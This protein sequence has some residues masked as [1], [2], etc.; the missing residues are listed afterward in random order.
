MTIRNITILL[1]TFRE[2]MDAA[3]VNY[4]KMNSTWNSDGKFKG[5]SSED[6]DEERVSKTSILDV[7]YVCNQTLPRTNV[8]ILNDRMSDHFPLLLEVM[9]SK[10]ATAARTIYRRNIKSLTVEKWEAALTACGHDWDIVYTK[11]WEV[12]ELSE[13]IEIGLNKAQDIAAPMRKVT[14]KPGKKLYLQPD[15]L[16]LMNLRDKTTRNSKLRKH[17]QNRVLCLVKR[18]HM[19]TAMRDIAEGIPATIWDITN[20][21]LGKGEKKLPTLLATDKETAE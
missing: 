16:H 9:P 5:K 19:I 4:L 11:D 10:A 18:D 12:D 15:T 8:H 2:G 7:I 13:Y 14:I 6:K 20:K 3:G 17:L 21:I 1:R